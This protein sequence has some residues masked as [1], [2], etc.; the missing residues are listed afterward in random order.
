MIVIKGI[1]RFGQ[2]NRFPGTPKLIGCSF[3]ERQDNGFCKTMSL[4]A[5]RFLEK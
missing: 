2:V 3:V 1:H 4:K 5:G